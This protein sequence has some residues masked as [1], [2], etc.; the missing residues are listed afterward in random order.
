M[1]YWTAQIH[2][3]KE[4]EKNEEIRAVE[5]LKD[6]DD[7]QIGEFM[8]TVWQRGFKLQ[9]SPIMWEFVS[10]FRILCIYVIKQDKKY[11]L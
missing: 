5:E 8:A 10:P 2:Y 7:K 1:N 11:S 4:K 6:Y 3:L 9:M